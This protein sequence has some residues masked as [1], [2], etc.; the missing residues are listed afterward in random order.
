LKTPS[1]SLA[2][3]SS[4]PKEEEE[5]EEAE[6]EGSLQNQELNKTDIHLPHTS[7]KT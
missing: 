3:G 7:Q 2:L 4:I 5:E 1:R 6:T